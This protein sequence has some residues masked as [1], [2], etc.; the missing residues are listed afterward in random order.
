MP[1]GSRSRGLVAVRRSARGVIRCGP[2]T[3]DPYDVPEIPPALGSVVEE[4][5]GS[6]PFA[7]IHGEAPGRLR[8]LGA[9]RRRRDAGRPRDA[10]GRPRRLGRAVRAARRAVPDDARRVRR[11]LREHRA[12]TRDTVVVGVRPVTDTVKRVEDGAVGE[13]VTAT[14]WSS[15][16]SP[17]VLPPGVVAALDGLPSLDFADAGGGAARAVPGRAASRRR[18]TAAGSPRRTTSGCSRRSPSVGTRAPGPAAGPSDARQ[19][20]RPAPRP[21][22]T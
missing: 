9:G 8:V 16:A 3:H 14:A 11:R 10:V 13:T 20:R 1:P 2:M 17:V 18:P 15:V 19:P 21:R 6:L 4:G 12:S 7:L 5:R 22:G